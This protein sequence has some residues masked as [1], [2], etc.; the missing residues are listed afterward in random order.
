MLLSVPLTI[1]A[2]IA[3]D[4]REESRW[5]AVLLGPD[6]SKQTTQEEEDATESSEAET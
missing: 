3:L 4:S 1:M 5:L 6:I 2:K